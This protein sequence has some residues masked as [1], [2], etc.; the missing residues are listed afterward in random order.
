MA[1]RPPP[2]KARAKTLSRYVDLAQY[3]GLIEGRPTKSAKDKLRRH[4]NA[5]AEFKRSRPNVQVY[6]PRTM[7]RARKL[8]A[9]LHPERRDV[10]P[11]IKS[12]KVVFLPDVGPGKVTRVEIRKG[13]V[14]ISR[15]V[16]GKRRRSRIIRLTWAQKLA[17]AS[18]PG[19]VQDIIGP[20]APGERV[21]IDTVSG[22]QV[23]TGRDPAFDWQYEDLDDLDVAL[24]EMD[25]DSEEIQVWLSG[26]TVVG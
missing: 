26:F 7:A 20:L 2:W 14:E 18:Q 9:L 11:R 24:G 5:L 25:T 8:Q 22:A 23:G 15:T 4:Y 1:K 10:L 17:V 3:P 12:L 13:Q 19:A 6:R 21:R 16:Q